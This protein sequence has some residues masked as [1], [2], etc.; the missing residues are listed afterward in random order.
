MDSYV[1]KSQNLNK[2]EVE[3]E[4]VGSDFAKTWHILSQFLC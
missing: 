2:G 4:Y 3:S 1:D